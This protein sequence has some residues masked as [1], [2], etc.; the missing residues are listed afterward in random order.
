[1]AI[2]VAVALFFIAPNMRYNP[3]ASQI[4]LEIRKHM[5]RY[6]ESEFS[7]NFLD[8]LQNEYRC[9]DTLWFQSNFNHDLPM[10]CLEPNDGSYN[11]ARQ[12]VSQSVGRLLE[13]V[14]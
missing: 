2:L 7:Y 1:M 14:A 11:V 8:L 6:Y 5:R 3:L 10:S 12:R 13:R 9:C 4:E